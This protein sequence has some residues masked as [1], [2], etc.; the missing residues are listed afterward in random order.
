MNSTWSYC[1]VKL[2]ETVRSS[3]QASASSSW[4]CSPR[5]RCR[6]WS[7]RGSLAKAPIVVLHERRQELV[8]CLDRRDAG[9]PHLFHEP[10]LQGAVGPLDPTLGLGCVGADDVNVQL[11]ERPTEL[12]HAVA[13]RRVL[14]IDP[15]HTVLVRVERHRLAVPLQIGPRGLEVVEGR[16]G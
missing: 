5:G 13:A 3:F 8:A 1:S 2:F 11:I 12:G 14:A 15:E 4:S 16:L 6:S 7:E 10:V 9:Q